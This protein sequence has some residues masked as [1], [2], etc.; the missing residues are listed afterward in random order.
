[1]KKL[2]LL[3]A[4]LTLALNMYA[5]EGDRY[6]DYDSG[7][8]FEE[9][10]IPNDW[11]G[12]DTFSRVV[13][14]DNYN[15]FT[16]VTIPGH[17]LYGPVIVG[18]DAF[19]YSPYLGDVVM[20]EGVVGIEPHAF[21]LTNY[22][23]PN[24][25]VTIPSTVRYIEH[26]A[27]AEE[28][29]T[30]TDN[31]E[32]YFSA[33]T[34]V[35]DLYITDL[36]AWCKIDFRGPGAN[37][38]G[39]MHLNGELIRNLELPYGLTKV[40][41]YC[42]R[43]CGEAFES[44]TLP[45]GIT[46]IGK[47]AFMGCYATEMDLSQITDIERQAFMN[48]SLTSA[49][50]SSTHAI[51]LMAFNGCSNLKEV[52]L[53]RALLDYDAGV[54]GNCENLEAINVEEGNPNYYFHDGVLYEYILRIG[55]T[56]RQVPVAKKEFE[57][58][59]DMPYPIRTIG[60]KAFDGC[61][62]ITHIDIPESVETID[63]EAF[64]N[65]SIRNLWIPP[66]VRQIWDG[67]F[68]FMDTLV[69]PSGSGTL[70]TN[71]TMELQPFCNLHNGDCSARTI[72]LGR[73][74]VYVDPKTG[75]ETP[76]GYYLGARNGN[77]IV[78]TLYLNNISSVRCSSEEIKNIYLN[79]AGTGEFS[80][81]AYESGRLFVDENDIDR[82]RNDNQWS[83][84]KLIIPWTPT[85]PDC[86]T[87][88]KIVEGQ[89]EY[90]IISE[91]GTCELA[92]SIKPSNADEE[93]FSVPETVFD[94]REYT[95][96]GIAAG[97]LLKTN[98]KTLNIPASV[99]YMDHSSFIGFSDLTTVNCLAAEPPI[100]N[101]VWDSYSYY[102]P[103]ASRVYANATLRV[104]EGSAEKYRTAHF[105]K[106]FKNIEELPKSGIT[107]I[108]AQTVNLTVADGVVSISGLTGEYE[109][110]VYDMTGRMVRSGKNLS[111]ITG[112]PAGD[113]ILNI[114]AVKTTK[115]RL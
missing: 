85:A 57:F 107:D 47:E 114:P 77:S 80:T 55:L 61:K 92:S 39:R 46:T 5:A 43:S 59:E 62:N 51:G 87:P 82:Y 74:V 89:F 68:Y 86:I 52:T 113:Y 12:Y 115:I 83:K 110:R 18:E 95:V 109:V 54:F 98:A 106:E 35:D 91:N 64:Y 20:E 41:D 94:G 70:K 21:D 100:V 4:V 102:N 112:L 10:H 75:K 2:I 38:G 108:A 53:S 65:S 60:R 99:M 3:A 15:D 17:G 33:T 56:L 31:A 90:N 36:D 101:R 76:V 13:H 42:F 6:T 25:S 37:P 93:S 96:I 72:Y 44:V 14:D 78:S 88:N 84:F 45:W 29:F 81:Q 26:S 1:M 28:Y 19:R 104:P 63:W 97:T 67:A 103:F 23:L 16:S 30:G 48:S 34:E 71:D 69:I 111:H 105:W 50:L 27:F 24:I 66:T 79:G 9:A 73:D 32:D 7:L 22:S 8:I 49:N 11:G 58:P 40:N